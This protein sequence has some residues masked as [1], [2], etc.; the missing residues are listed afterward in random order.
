[1]TSTLYITRGVPGSGKST[2]ARKWVDENP[3]RRVRINRDDI[4]FMLFGK[5]WGVDEKAVTRVQDTL[6][7]ASLADGKDVI[8]DNTNLQSKNVIDLLKIAAEKSGV[9]V[10]F[11]DF[12]ISFEEAVARDAA[13]DRTVGGDVIRGFYN[14]FLGGVKK[15]IF[16]ANPVLPDEWVFEPYE[17]VAGLPRA[18]LIDIDGTLAHHEGIRSPYD[19]TRY[20]ED[21]FDQT[22]ADIAWHYS[23]YAG[24]TSADPTRVRRVVL[25]GRDAA[26][27]QDLVDWLD[28]HDFPV[29]EIYMRK[30]GDVRNDAVVKN[31]LFEENIRGRYNVDFVMDDRPRVVRMWQQKGLK[32]LNVGIMDIEF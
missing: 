23:Q 12:P 15:G 22:V 1:M 27:K 13:R 4:R 25:S 32:V 26:Y 9:S 31:E 8:V 7:R 24:K 3:S 20:G 16:P 6:L 17:A 2:Y 19:V 28:K 29:D 18:I 11:V 21:T 30:V 14:R 5:Y 10:E